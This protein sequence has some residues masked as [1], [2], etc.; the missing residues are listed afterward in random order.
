[1]TFCGMA[2][3]QCSHAGENV[4]VTATSMGI[5]TGNGHCNG[6]CPRSGVSMTKCLYSDLPYP[7]SRPL[8]SPPVIAE[9]RSVGVVAAVSNVTIGLVSQS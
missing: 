6:E 7:V 3:E 4:P 8:F 5:G 2:A 1:M 9:T